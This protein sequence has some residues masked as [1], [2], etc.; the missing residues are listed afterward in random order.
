MKNRSVGESKYTL[1]KMLG[2]VIDD[3]T[4]FSVALIRLIFLIGFVVFLSRILMVLY[5]FGT[6]LF[7]NR[8]L[9]GWTSTLLPIYFIGGIQILSI[10]IIGEYIGKLYKEVK[11]RPRYFI[12]SSTDD[13]E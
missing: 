6:F 2:F 8:A 12:E 10:G 3:I 13:G 4:S 9:P 1:S 7:I 11:R 5:I